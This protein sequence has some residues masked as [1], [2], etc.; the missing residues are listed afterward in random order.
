MKLLPYLKQGTNTFVFKEKN[1]MTVAGFKIN[2]SKVVVYWRFENVNEDTTVKLTAQ[3]GSVTSLAFG[4][5]YWSF[6]DIKAKF[7]GWC[8][9]A[10]KHL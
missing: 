3:D 8:G 10:S 2:I 1:L 9:I 6:S 7:A 5:G 4:K